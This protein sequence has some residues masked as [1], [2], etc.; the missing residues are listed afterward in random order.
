MPGGQRWAPFF[1][2]SIKDRQTESSFSTG[3]GGFQGHGESRGRRTERGMQKKRKR[4]RE[5]KRLFR[6]TKKNRTR[7]RWNNIL[8]KEIRVKGRGAKRMEG[9]KEKQSCQP[10]KIESLALVTNEK[11]QAEG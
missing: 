7:K 2:E 5:T 4:K 1:S 10:Y 11:V 8:T 6:K 9:K 3:E